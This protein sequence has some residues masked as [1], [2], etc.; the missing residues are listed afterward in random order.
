MNLCGMSKEI[1]EGRLEL[2]ISEKSHCS[3]FTSR[4]HICI[5]NRAQ[6]SDAP[7]YT[8]YSKRGPREHKLNILSLPALQF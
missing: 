8:V 2:K 6:N 7:K 1:T 4:G 3:N 5:N